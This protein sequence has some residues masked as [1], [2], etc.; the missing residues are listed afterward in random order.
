MFGTQFQGATLGRLLTAWSTAGILG[1]VV[2]NYMH[3]TGLEAGVP[4]D[5]VYGPIFLTLA[6]LLVI[7]FIAN[8]LV[9][10]IADKYYMTDAE[11]A[12]EHKLAHDQSLAANKASGAGGAAVATKPDS[13]PI[14]T[15]FAWA[16]VLI[17]ISYGVWS[18]I[19]QTW[20][21]FN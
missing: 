15:A 4:F 9:K 12:A 21:L 19:Q 16:F 17:P 6:G 2:V 11:L 13:Q 8:L 14:F 1:P 20:V 3:D 5:Q 18:T 7:G 10:P